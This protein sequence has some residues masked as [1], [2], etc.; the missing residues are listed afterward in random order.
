MTSSRPPALDDPQLLDYLAAFSAGPDFRPGSLML[1]LADDRA[2]VLLAAAID[3][4][5]PSYPQHERIALL[6][7]LFNGMAAGEHTSLAGL[8]LLVCREGFPDVGGEDLGWHDATRTACL[9]A[10]LTWYGA[11]VVTDRG[12]STLGPPLAA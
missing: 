5:D 7:E 11:F 3:D 10:G 2:E 1:L 6:G 8:G 4:V 9:A 12:A